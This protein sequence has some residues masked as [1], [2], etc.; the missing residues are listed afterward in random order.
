MCW[1]EIKETRKKK[2]KWNPT[3]RHLRRSTDERDERGE[4][5]RGRPKDADGGTRGIQGGRKRKKQREWKREKRRG[6]S[7][8]TEIGRNTKAHTGGEDTRD[9][10]RQNR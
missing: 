9:A 1:W 6:K 8:A 3:W 7:G 2:K 4:T 5:E 10:T